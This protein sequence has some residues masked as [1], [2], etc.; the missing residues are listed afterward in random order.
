MKVKLDALNVVNEFTLYEGEGHG[1][2]GLN[3]LDTSIKLNA[4]IDTHLVN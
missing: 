4:F 1:W 2:I 3:A